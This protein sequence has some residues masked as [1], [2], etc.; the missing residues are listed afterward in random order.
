M[1]Q[2]YGFYLRLLDEICDTY[3]LEINSRASE[4]Q[5]KMINTMAHDKGTLYVLF[6]IIKKELFSE[7]PRSASSNYIAQHCLVHLG[8]IARYRHKGSMADSYYR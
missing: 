2:A 4:K 6:N 5:L 3:A 7:K 8:D 1:E